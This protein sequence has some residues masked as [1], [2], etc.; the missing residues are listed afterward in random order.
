MSKPFNTLVVDCEACLHNE[1]QKNT[2]LFEKITQIQVETDNEYEEL[3][4]KLGMQSIHIGYGTSCETYV[5][6]KYT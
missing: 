6:E 2:D 1:Y 4:K 3:F 5:Y